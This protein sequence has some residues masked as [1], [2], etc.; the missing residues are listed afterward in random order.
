MARK[1]RKDQRVPPIFLFIEL[2]VPWLV[3][4]LVAILMALA[5]FNVEIIFIASIACAVAAT[6]LM[7]EFEKSRKRRRIQRRK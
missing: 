4:G 3:M 7:R 1:L 6:F 5:R 2:V